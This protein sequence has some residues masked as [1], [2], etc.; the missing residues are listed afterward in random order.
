MYMTHNAKSLSQGL[1]KFPENENITFPV[2]CRHQGLSAAGIIRGES[3]TDALSLHYAIYVDTMWPQ[4]GRQTTWH[5]RPFPKSFL[6]VSE[7]PL[8]SSNLPLYGMPRNVLPINT[9]FSS[10]N[11]R[12]PAGR[13]L[14]QFWKMHPACNLLPTFSSNAPLLLS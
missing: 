7:W 4:A 12:M 10:M 9:P 13:T 6:R 2:I 5:S 3:G 8:V 11:S 1:H 14:Y